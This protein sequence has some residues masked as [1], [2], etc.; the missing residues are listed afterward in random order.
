MLLAKDLGSL[1]R[2]HMSLTAIHSSSY[3][4]SN[5]L[6]WPLWAA[7]K[8]MM[9]I[10]TERQN[11]QINLK[12]KNIFKPQKLCSFTRKSIHRASKMFS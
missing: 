10:H 4:R 12:I 1:S 2:T 9:H 7:D 6:F 8:Y 11:T 5:A 3:R